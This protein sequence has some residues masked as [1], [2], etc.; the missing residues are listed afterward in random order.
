MT[1]PSSFGSG[2]PFGDLFS[3]FFGTSPHSSPPAA[4]RAAEDGSTDLDTGHLLWAATPVEATAGRLDPVVGRAG[5]RVRLRDLGS[6]GESQRTKDRI[7]KLR[8]ELDEA[9]TAVAQAVRRGRAG[10]GDPDRPTGSF[11]FCT[12]ARPAASAATPRA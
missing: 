3:R 1:F 11:L 7:A 6:S 10:M 12:L 5:A 2:D 4:Q 9:V 8:R